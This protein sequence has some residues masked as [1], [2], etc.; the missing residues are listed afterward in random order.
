MFCNASVCGCCVTVL[1]V[2]VV[3]YKFIEVACHH[4]API[5][6]IILYGVLGDYV[7][8]TLPLVALVVK[9]L[10]FLLEKVKK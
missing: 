4:P 3:L 8:I 2:G 5:N 10:L 9:C 7:W 1:D 6:I